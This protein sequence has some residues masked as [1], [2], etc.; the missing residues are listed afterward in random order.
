[1]YR[2]KFSLWHCVLPL[3]YK[4]ISSNLFIKIRDLIVCNGWVSPAL[5]GKRYRFVEKVFIIVICC[6]DFYWRKVTNNV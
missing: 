4:I 1:M 2:N 5:Y 3:A 6:K